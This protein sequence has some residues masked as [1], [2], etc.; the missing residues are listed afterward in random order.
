MVGFTVSSSKHL[1]VICSELTLIEL[2]ERL[3][4][5]RSASESPLL[6]SLLH[7]ELSGQVN[8]VLRDHL[9][10]MGVF[11]HTSTLG[12]Q[13]IDSIFTLSAGTV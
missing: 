12:L 5:E 9:I 6:S 2:S 4:G 11:V 13:H 1:S 10:R 3:C 8:L 7:L